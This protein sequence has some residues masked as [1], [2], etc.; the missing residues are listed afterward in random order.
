[1]ATRTLAEITRK[2]SLE[3]SSEMPRNMTASSDATMTS[4]VLAFFHSGGRKALTR[5]EMA[6]TPVTR[7]H[8]TRRPASPRRAKHPMN[9]PVPS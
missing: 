1:M 6:S 5:L 4:V 7:P 2:W 9:R 8:P 3:F